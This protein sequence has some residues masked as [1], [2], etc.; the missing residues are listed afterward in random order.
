MRVLRLYLHKHDALLVNATAIFCLS[1]RGRTM[2]LPRFGGSRPQEADMGAG[3][4]DAAGGLNPVHARHFE[5]HQDDIGLQGFSDRFGEKKENR[6]SLGTRRSS[7]S[8]STSS[9]G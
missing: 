5:I 6:I 4:Q 7:S 9:R 8:Q 1:W 3:V 2:G